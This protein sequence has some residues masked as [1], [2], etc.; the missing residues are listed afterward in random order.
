MSAKLKNPTL[1]LL[2]FLLAMP[3]TG[4]PAND[5]THGMQQ[6]VQ[7][8]QSGLQQIQQAGGDPRP[9]VQQ[10][11]QVK[12]L[13][14]RQDFQRADAKLDGI[15]A[16][17]DNTLQDL[18]PALVATDEVRSGHACGAAPAKLSASTICVKAPHEKIKIIGDAPRSGIFDPSIEY[19]TDGI[20]WLAYSAVFGDQAPFGP[21][22]ETH[23]AKSLDN[24][25]SWQYVGKIN[26]SSEGTFKQSDGSVVEGN[27]NYEVSTLVYDPE[28]T[29]KEWKIFAHRAL[30]LK[31]QKQGKPGNAHPYTLPSSTV[32]YRHAPHP[33]GPWSAAISLFHGKALPDSYANDVR[34]NLN[35]LHPDLSEHVV[36]SELGS[37]VVDGVLYLSLSALKIDGS[38]QVILLVSDDHAETWR[39]VGTLIKRSDAAM[40]GHHAFDGSSLVKLKKRLFLLASPMT[41]N[42]GANQYN[43]TLVFEIED[44]SSAKLK[45]DDRG[46]PATYYY[47]EPNQSMWSGNGGGTADYDEQNTA[48]GIV[49]SQ[50]SIKSAPEIFQVFNSKQ[51]IIY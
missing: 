25:K 36:F 12:V 13:L 45:R 39:Y 37:V 51:N 26:E 14:D 19:D 23:L 16:L 29:G 40:F 18:S 28:D 8:V 44:I 24:G 34:I 9:I 41:R 6:K 42:N 35:K 4:C 30:F 7:Q 11:K 47:I 15:L 20:G 3:L 10:M 46:I 2:T 48:G 22:V 50:I 49:M 32:V 43:G 38:D 17:I 31:N 21:Y 1:V 5:K 27:W 33:A